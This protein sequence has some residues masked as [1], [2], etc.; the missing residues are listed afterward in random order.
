MEKVLIIDDFEPVRKVIKRIVER[1]QFTAL[2]ACD[3]KEGLEVFERERPEVIITDLKMPNIDGKGVLCA[4]KS[5]HPETEVIVLTGYGDSE[6]ANFLLKNG[7]FSYLKKPLDLHQLVKILSEVRNKIRKN[8]VKPLPLPLLSSSQNDETVSLY[9]SP[10]GKIKILWDGD[11]KEKAR[12]FMSLGANSL[13]LPLI[14][15]NNKRDILYS[16]RAFE[17]IVGNGIRRL[18]ESVLIEIRSHGVNLAPSQKFFGAL[19]HLLD[20]LGEDAAAPDMDAVG[21]VIIF[22]VMAIKDSEEM[23][24]LLLSF[25][26]LM[27]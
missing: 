18:E 26:G 14:V 1:E 12:Q 27:A 24:L 19:S 9:F 2:Q 20:E 5:Q 6:M 17:R 25:P 13:A 3:G 16:N 11:T 8:G 10:D 7:A 22:K 23:P 4:V 21:D 15:I